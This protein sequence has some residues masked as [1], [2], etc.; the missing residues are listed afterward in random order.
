MPWKK[1]PCPQCGKPKS[2]S[3]KLCRKCS[4]PYERTEQWRENLSKKLKGRQQRGVGWHH[5]KATKE[6]MARHWTPEKRKAKSI[7]QQLYYE[8]YQNRMAIALKLLGDK[9]PNYQ[10]KGKATDYGPGY[11]AKYAKLL[12]K[13][14]GK[15]ERCGKTNCF[16]DLHHKDF[17]LTNH[18]PENLLCVCR[19]CHKLIHSKHK[20]SLGE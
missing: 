2:K 15:C 5:S 10:A 7:E 13:R 6:K 20:Q 1:V 3:A 8:D 11:G 14:R 9:N 12:K 17:G 19:S 4:K 18:L 16:L